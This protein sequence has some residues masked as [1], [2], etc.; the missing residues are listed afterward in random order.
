M[1]KAI[2][3]NTLF[4]LVIAVAALFL[5]VYSNA[6]YSDYTEN[7]TQLEAMDWYMQNHDAST[8]ELRVTLPLR[9]MISSAIG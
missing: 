3:A 7:M 4:A 1:F 2:V 8:F 6:I 9:Y 5:F